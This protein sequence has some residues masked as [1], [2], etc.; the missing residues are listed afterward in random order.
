MAK[1]EAGKLVL[2]RDSLAF[3]EFIEQLV[4]MF[5]LQAEA[6]ELVLK[7]EID[8]PLPP[9]VLTDEKRL[10]QILINLLSNAIKY[11]E[12]GSVILRIAYR[13]QI[14]EFE[15]RDTGIGIEAAELKRI[16]EPFERGTSAAGVTGTGLGLT[17]SDL[18][19]QVMG[20]DI[21]VNSVPGVGSAFRLRMLLTAGSKEMA[22]L[23]T[24]ARI[25]G[26]RGPRKKVLV[27][28]DDSDHRMLMDDSLGA[29][30][31]TLFTASDGAQCLQFLPQCTPDLLLL[32]IS[33]P[34]IDGWEVVRR[35]RAMG[36]NRLPVIIVSANA[37]ESQHP[38]GD[39]S[40]NW[41]FLVKPVVIPQLLNLLQ[42]HLSLEWTF[43]ADEPTQP[44]INN[45]SDIAI[46]NLEETQI[47]E[48][49]ALGNIGYVRGIESKLTSLQQMSPESRPVLDKLAEY[50]RT[51]Q[52]KSYLNT[53]EALRHR[54]K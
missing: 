30:G 38:R 17:I 11:T 33:M 49:I 31:F 26:Y 12:K 53:L 27:V 9:V 45:S 32:D 18:L 51:F 46:S 6:K 22:L 2:R 8:T 10:R 43:A 42:K 34:G 14:V 23:P 21:S 13:R 16:F 7:L 50:V 24:E 40:Q 28:D 20:G 36:F 41:D 29:L 15:V 3:P 1:I 44:R 39:T 19:A 37:F 47:E 52:F 5:E 25:T 4:Q 54:D 35:I 48:L